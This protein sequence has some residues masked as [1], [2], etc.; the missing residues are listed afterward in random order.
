MREIVKADEPLRAR[1]RSATTTAL[2][3]FADQPYKRE[4]IEKVDGER[5]RGRGRGRRRC[6][7]SVYRNVATPTAPSSSTCAAVRTSRRRSGSAR[8]SSPRS[9]ARTGGATRRARCCS[10]STAPRGSRR[11]ALD[12]H[13][14]RLEEA[15]R[16][17]HRKL[18]VELD[19][20]SFPEEIGSGLAVFHP[21]GAL[22]RKHHGG[23]LAP[24]AR[25]RPATSFVNSPHI[26][27]ADLFETSG[28]L[29]WFADG[30]FPPMHA[31]RGRRA[32]ARRTTSSR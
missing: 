16:R 28:H 3:L 1:R 10:A 29:D 27:K 12:E 24:A 18:G 22:V 5:R 14:H 31:R 9:P 26:T 13:L 17:D 7:V 30:M 8:S 6:G 20:F 25:G 19:L 32:R 21:K 2:A 15:E 4:I 23:L 11:P